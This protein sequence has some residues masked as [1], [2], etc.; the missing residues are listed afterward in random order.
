M[1]YLERGDSAGAA[2][3]YET[4]LAASPP[5]PPGAAPGESY[6]TNPISVPSRC[7]SNHLSPHKS[8]LAYAFAH[9]PYRRPQETPN[10]PI[11]PLSSL[12]NSAATPPGPPGTPS[13]ESYQTNPISVPSR[14]FSNYLSPHKSNPPDAFAPAPYRRPQETPNEPILPLNP[15]PNHDRSSREISTSASCNGRGPARRGESHPCLRNVAA[16]RC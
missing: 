9:A 2:D 8:N 5:A 10:E 6:Q 3:R 13:S 16:R 4:Q 12:P 14:C 11:L 1:L 15:S 7:F